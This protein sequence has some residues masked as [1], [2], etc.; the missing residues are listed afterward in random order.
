M[1]V[2][3][4]FKGSHVAWEYQGLNFKRGVTMCGCIVEGVYCLRGLG[5]H[6]KSVGCHGKSSVSSI[7]IRVALY[8]VVLCLDGAVR[9]V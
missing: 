6:F 7:D 2:G 5:A 8:C 9:Q 3:E 1:C 4:I